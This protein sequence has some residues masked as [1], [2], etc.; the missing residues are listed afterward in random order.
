M[1]PPAA[2]RASGAEIEAEAGLSQDADF[3]AVQVVEG[4]DEVLRTATPSAELGDQ[5]RVDFVCS[6]EFKDLGTARGARC[7]QLSGSP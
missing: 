5:D 6:R 3:P 4:L 7:G 1:L 2:A